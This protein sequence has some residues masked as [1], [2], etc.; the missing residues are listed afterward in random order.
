VKEAHRQAEEGQRRLKR[1]EGVAHDLE[2]G[3]HEIEKRMHDAESMVK[4]V[5]KRGEPE[6]EA[7]LG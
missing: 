6:D 5:A 3:L 4:N 7:G 2:E 1:L